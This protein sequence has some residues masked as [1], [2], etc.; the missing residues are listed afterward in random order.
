MKN[1]IFFLASLKYGR[2]ESNLESDPR[3]RIRT[4]MSRIPSTAYMWA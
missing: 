4:K 1:I 3:I 2:N